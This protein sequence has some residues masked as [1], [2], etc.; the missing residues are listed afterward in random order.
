MLVDCQMD[1]AVVMDSSRN[2]GQRRFNL[3]KNFVA[4]LA[5]MLRVGASG[6]RVGLIQARSVSHAHTH[7]RFW[8][9]FLLNAV[10]L[11]IEAVTRQRPSLCWAAT[12][13][14][15][16]CCLPSRSWP[17]WGVTATQVSPT[18]V[19]RVLFTE[20]AKNLLKKRRIWKN[21]SS[22]GWGSCHCVRQ[23]PWTEWPDCSHN[24]FLFCLWV[25]NFATS[26]MHLHALIV[27]WLMY[28]IQNESWAK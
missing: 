20:T 1:V 8:C 5:A 24:S 6:P 13:S 2:I 28:K 18:P 19:P 15:K 4:K 27:L 16:T 23:P 14:P 22:F 10:R 26:K 25:K 21:W 12:L 11:R 3:Q 7:T 17:S 9:Y